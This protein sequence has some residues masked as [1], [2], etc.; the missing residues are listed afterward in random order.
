MKQFNK[1]RIVG[2][3]LAAGWLISLMLPARDYRDY[4]HP[5]TF[6][7]P[8]TY[9]GCVDFPLPDQADYYDLQSWKFEQ[10]VQFN[11]R[12]KIGLFNVRNLEFPG[13]GAKMVC[14]WNGKSGDPFE[15]EAKFQ[16]INNWREK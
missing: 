15:V 10:P 11:F 12:G 7:L 16:M 1:I 6:T 14:D 4:S 13:G 5:Y 8:L 3:I 2:G 9:F